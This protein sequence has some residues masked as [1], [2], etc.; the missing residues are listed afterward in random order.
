M[1]PSPHQSQQHLLLPFPPQHFP[2][3]CIH[4]TWHA[5]TFSATPPNKSFTPMVSYTLV[6]QLG[7]LN[8]HNHLA[9]TTYNRFTP[10]NVPSHMSSFSSSNLAFSLHLPSQPCSM[11]TPVLA[12]SI[13]NGTASMTCPSRTF[14]YQIHVGKPRLKL[15]MIVSTSACHVFCISTVI[16]LLSIAT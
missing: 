11:P 1:V 12:T 15:T 13:V 8:L 2:S 14:A 10:W 7:R 4:N 9:K 16:L 6:Q 3:P 5:P